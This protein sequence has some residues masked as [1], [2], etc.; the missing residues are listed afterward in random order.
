[1]LS[2]PNLI[3]RKK[4]IEGEKAERFNLSNGVKADSSIVVYTR[5]KIIWHL[6]LYFSSNDGI[7][8]AHVLM[9]QVEG[10]GS[11]YYILNCYGICSKWR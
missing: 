1:M 6:L 10:R 8:I 11:V 3:I 4:K 2:L 7:L 5:D 9:A